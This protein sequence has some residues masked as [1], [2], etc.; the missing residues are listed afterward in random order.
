MTFTLPEHLVTEF[1]RRVPPSSRSQYVAT[2]IAAKLREREQQLARACELA[3]NS[4]DVSD[5][6]TSLESLADESDRVQEPW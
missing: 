4:A 5:I 3:N 2:A 1:L 6:E